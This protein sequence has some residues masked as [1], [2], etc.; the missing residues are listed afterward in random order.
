MS[1]EL[2][3]QELMLL[4][5]AII[6]F[7]WRMPGSHLGRHL[8]LVYDRNHHFHLGRILKPKPKLAGT[9]TTFQ[10]EN[11]ADNLALV[12]GIFSIIKC[13]QILNIFKIFLKTGVYFQA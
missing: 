9:E 8:Q 2:L 11:L 4:L 6:G 5:D 3:I 12:L 10:R 1:E 13:W 7:L